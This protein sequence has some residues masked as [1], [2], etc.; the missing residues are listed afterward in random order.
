MYTFASTVAL[1]YVDEK[2]PVGS[3]IAQS[4]KLIPR[5]LQVL[6]ATSGRLDKQHS[7][8]TVLYLENFNGWIS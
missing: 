4:I 5:T 8:I 1:I 2:L 7:W 6:G 3:G